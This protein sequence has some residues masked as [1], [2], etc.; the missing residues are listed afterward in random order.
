M[1]PIRFMALPPLHL[2]LRP[3]L[4]MKGTPT[5]RPVLAPKCHVRSLAC[6]PSV[7][8]DTSS[9]ARRTTRAL[10]G[11]ENSMNRFNSTNGRTAYSARRFVKASF[12]IFGTRDRRRKQARGWTAIKT[13][14]LLQIYVGLYRNACLFTCIQVRIFH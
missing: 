9:L 11:V 13:F 7:S 10:S 8:R 1:I 5:A 12:D 3:S 14:L 4:V 6:A 2:L